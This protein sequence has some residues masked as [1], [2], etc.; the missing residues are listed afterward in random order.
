MFDDSAI[1]PKFRPATSAEISTGR[2]EVSATVNGVTV[3]TK[4]P[5]LDLA[6]AILAEALERPFA[7]DSNAHGGIYDRR[8]FRTVHSWRGGYRAPLVNPIIAMFER[9]IA[10]GAKVMLATPAAVVEFEGGRAA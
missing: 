6:R 2:F 7:D 3:T 4:V 9:A 8:S 1:A 5:D 10:S